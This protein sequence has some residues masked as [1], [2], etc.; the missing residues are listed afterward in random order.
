MSR[1]KKDWF[2]RA[3]GLFVPHPLLWSP[4]Y[5]CCCGE[6]C[7]CDVCG[8]FSD[9]FSTEKDKWT[10]SGGWEIVDEK[11]HSIPPRGAGGQSTCRH[12]FAWPA[13]SGFQI[14]AEADVAYLEPTESPNSYVWKVVLLNWNASFAN[15]YMWIRWLYN[16]STEV[17]YSTIGYVTPS[18]SVTLYTDIEE[19]VG[20]SHRLGCEVVEGDGEKYDIKL[21]LDGELEATVSDITINTSLIYECPWAGVSGMSDALT[22]DWRTTVDNYA[23]VS[24]Y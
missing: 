22:P 13:Y 23:F 24:S 17:L 16:T 3:S 6:P 12:S 21:Y 20:D 11:L 19:S 7:E 5:P 4:G 14:K 2:R 15:A 9:D 18:G 8:N 10:T 1:V